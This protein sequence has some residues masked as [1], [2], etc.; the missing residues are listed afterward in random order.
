V[1]SASVRLTTC[2]KLTATLSLL[3]GP[4]QADLAKET[5]SG[6]GSAN[7]PFIRWPGSLTLSAASPAD[8]V[9]VAVV[10]AS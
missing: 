9:T 1:R 5:C 10:D 8:E 2:L 7:V 3:V 6:S 4:V